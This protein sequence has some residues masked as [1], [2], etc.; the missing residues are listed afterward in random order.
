MN[1]NDFSKLKRIFT[2]ISAYFND[3]RTLFEKHNL[4][5]MPPSYV[6]IP[7][8]APIRVAID[9]GDFGR[10][11]LATY[12]GVKTNLE[13]IS[14][15]VELI[16]I[17]VSNATDQLQIDIDTNTA[18][19]TNVE[20]DI[21][22]LDTRLDAYDTRFPVGKVPVVKATGAW[23]QKFDNSGG[24]GGI[25]SQVTFT[26][27]PGVKY[28]IHM[29][30][31]ATNGA[32]PGAVTFINLVPSVWPLDL[33]SIWTT[34]SIDLNTMQQ[35]HVALSPANTRF[36]FYKSSSLVS[37]TGGGITIGGNYTVTVAGMG[38]GIIDSLWVD[39]YK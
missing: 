33:Q 10:A 21:S 9:D 12:N 16:V 34:G 30:G 38:Y 32:V 39:E 5:E 1:L 11:I 27:L 26:M 2:K 29:N 8:D 20:T 31:S 36:D 7:F 37:A 23:N 3:A 15:A 14:S 25:I 6:F 22:G 19:I 4:T 24:P 35:G 28:V 18:D 17:G 13:S